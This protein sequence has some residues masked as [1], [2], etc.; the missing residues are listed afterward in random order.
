MILPVLIVWLVDVISA[1]RIVRRLR[2]EDPGLGGS[3]E[4]VGGGSRVPR[5]RPSLDEFLRA[6]GEPIDETGFIRSKAPAMRV[7]QMSRR[8]R[9]FLVAR[10]PVLEPQRPA[11]VDKPP[12]PPGRFRD[13]AILLP[14]RPGRWTGPCRSLE[15]ADGIAGRFR[16][17]SARERR[18]PTTGEELCRQEPSSLEWPSSG[19]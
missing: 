15:W 8:H 13:F 11:S 17:A 4:A 5:T 3:A 14:R 1:V 16:W 10:P 19:S 12:V 7:P 18:D 9:A 6:S 2:R